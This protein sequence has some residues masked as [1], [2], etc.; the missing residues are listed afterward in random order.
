MIRNFS[1]G[2]HTRN[3]GG[4]LIKTDGDLP[5]LCLRQVDAPTEGAETPTDSRSRR[6]AQTVFGS[7]VTL[8]RALL[9]LALAVVVAVSA[10]AFSSLALKVDVKVSEEQAATLALTGGAV[11][12]AAALVD[13]ILAWFVLSGRNWARIWLMT[14]CVFSTTVAFVANVRGVEAITL[15]HL[16]TVGI[17]VLVLLALSSHRA[18]DYATGQRE[19][20]PR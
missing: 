2:Y 5:I 17:S 4:D 3:G 16:L 11:L 6:P 10:E 19:Q 14:V 15:S 8:L 9:Y 18:R 20:P 13:G 1:T 12:L 7:G